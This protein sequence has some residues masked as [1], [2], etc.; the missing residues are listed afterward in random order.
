M[1]MLNDKIN[2][3]LT[4]LRPKRLVIY[5]DNKTHEINLIEDR[6]F[7]MLNLLCTYIDI[8]EVTP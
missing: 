3:L 4:C 8:H 6:I 7:K 2:T 5:K 1:L